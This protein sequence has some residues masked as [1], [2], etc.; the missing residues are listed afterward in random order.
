MTQ[1]FPYLIFCHTWTA[2]SA[3]L[4]I[5]WFGLGNIPPQY[6][7]ELA[8]LR[9]FL[10]ER[11]DPTHVFVYMDVGELPAAL[12]S[13]DQWIRMNGVDCDLQGYI[14]TRL[15]VSRGEPG[16]RRR[17]NRVWALSLGLSGGGFLVREFRFRPRLM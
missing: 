8:R 10:S 12:I 9:L 14:T 11:S 7:K 4:S 13:N 5:D 3:L 1:R 16:A 17:P 2:A 15:R 6:A